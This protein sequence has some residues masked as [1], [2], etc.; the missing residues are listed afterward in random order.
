MI[1]AAFWLAGS[2][3]AADQFPPFDKSTQAVWQTLSSQ[4]YAKMSGKSDKE[5]RTIFVTLQ[6][7]LEASMTDTPFEKG[8]WI[9][10]T[11]LIATPVVTNGQLSEGLVAPEILKDP[12]TTRVDVALK[13]ADIIRTFLKKGGTLIIAHAANQREGSLG[14]TPEQIRIFEKLKKEYPKQLIEFGI[15]PKL[16]LNQE[17]PRDKIGATYFMER[18]GSDTLEIT[19]RGVQIHDAKPGTWGIWQQTREKPIALV[20]KQIQEIMQFLDKAGLHEKLIQHAQQHGLSPD[21]FFSL[22]TPYWI[23]GK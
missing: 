22:L 6:A 20:T 7:Y 1:T 13:R 19:Q 23:S 5:A 14:R 4:G 10:H 17:F 15:N 8:I 3:L 2:A 21:Q 12:D 9:I 16:L 18:Q 11:P